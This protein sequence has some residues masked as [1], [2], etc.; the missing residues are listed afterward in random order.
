[1]RD[2]S[3][4]AAAWEFVL[5]QGDEDLIGRFLRPA[6][7]IF[8]IQ[9]RYE[10]GEQL[11]N[12]A[13]TRLGASLD[14]DN[15]LIK[16]RALVLRAS[17]LQNLTQFDEAEQIIN[18]MLPTLRTFGD[19][20]LWETR[21]ALTSQGALVYARSDYEKAQVIFE[22]VYELSSKTDGDPVIILLRL[23]DIALVLGQYDKARTIM[24]KALEHLEDTGGDQSRMRFLLTLGDINVKLGNFAAAQ[25]NFTEALELCERLDAQTSGAVARVSLARV[26]YGL[27]DFSQSR[28]LC[29]E[30]IVIFDKIRNFWGKAFA[31]MHLGKATYALEDYAEAKFHYRTA[32]QIADEVGSPWLVAATLH[33]LSKANYQL[34]DEQAAK[35]NLQESLRVS[36]DIQALPLTMDAITGIAQMYTSQGNLEQASELALFV[37]NQ[38]VTEYETAQ[39]AQQLVKQLEGDMPP[40]SLAELRTQATDQPLD[41]VIKQILI[42]S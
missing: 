12:A 23:S 29:Q 19:E 32:R 4:I 27:G 6:Y 31:C 13:A 42:T 9:S 26:A 2:F 21:I 30:S 33:Y 20:A 14:K 40:D 8:D 15:N 11:F 18:A 37:L 5:D 25:S 24:E 22:E 34:G 28:A 1:M 38:P 17:C 3:N 39:E 10:D 35:Q 16:T 7:R 36:L 41:A